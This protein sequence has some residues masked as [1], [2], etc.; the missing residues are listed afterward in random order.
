MGLGQQISKRSGRR[1]QPFANLMFLSRRV[2]IGQSIDRRNNPSFHDSLSI[3]DEK[4]G[5]SNRKTV[6]LRRQEKIRRV[7]KLQSSERS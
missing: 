1:A 5:G 7:K 2:C 6:K 3:L 4:D